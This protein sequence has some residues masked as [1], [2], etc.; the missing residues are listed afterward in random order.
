[1]FKKVL[2]LIFS[3]FISS[4]LA[5]SNSNFCFQ[6]QITNREE[7]FNFKQRFEFYIDAFNKK[8]PKNE[9]NTKFEI[10]KENYIRVINDKS[11]LSMKKEDFSNLDQKVQTEL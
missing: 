9:Y 6:N 8:Y 3:L 10:F 7:C 4:S 2:F 11:Y 5:N 1:M